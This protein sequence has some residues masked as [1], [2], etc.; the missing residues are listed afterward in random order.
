M[1]IRV[2]Q[3]NVSPL[4][5]KEGVQASY[6]W[7]PVGNW[8]TLQDF[9]QQRFPFVALDIWQARAAKGELQ[10]QRGQHLTLEMPYRAGL[11]VF[12]YREL[13]RETP[14]PFQ[15]SL[16]HL[17]QH[18]LVVD[19]P[20]FLPVIPSGRFLQETLLVRLRKEYD[21][22]HLAPLHRLDR[23]TAGVVLFSHN[24]ASRGRYQNLF[25]QRV[26]EKTYEAVAA[27]LHA[28]DAAFPFLYASRI[29][30]G[31]PFFVMQE[32]AG[33]ANAQTWIDVLARR[34]RFWHYQLRPIT[35]RT[36]Q[37]RV[38]MN[39]LGCPILHDA[40]Y[41]I[42]L[43]CKGDD[44]ATPLQLLARSVTFPDPLTGET[45]HFCSQRQLQVWA[46]PSAS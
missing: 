44:F 40:F 20:H 11:Q 25:Q 43:P 24:P 7:L 45:R 21:L 39:A 17:D 1:S 28:R 31:E 27:P 42:A 15:A 32:V 46:N 4:P 22:P 29:E 41:P 3:K 37:L 8:A 34:E 16:L 23:E 12:Y 35:G 13:E 36:H 18:L 9:L 26:V 14:I 33:E 2:S 5:A 6:V 30:Q 19:K 10:D 38:H